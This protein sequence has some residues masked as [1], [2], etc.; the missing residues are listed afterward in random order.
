MPRDLLI[1]ARKFQ[2][3]L[4]YM[5]R[6]GL[7]GEAI[8]NPL[9]MTPQELARTA[10]EQQLLGSDYSRMYKNAA[11]QMQT[12]RWPIPWAAGI[13]SEA[14]EFMCQ[15]IITCKTLGEALERAQRYDKLLYPMIGYRMWIERDEAA[16]ELHYK[17]TVQEQDNVL[18]PEDWDRKAHV[19]TVARASGL[20]VWYSLCGWLIGRSIDL[21]RVEIGGPEVS[22]AYR[23]GLDQV[24][25]CPLQFDSDRNCFV[26]PASYLDYRLVHTPE[27]L[28]EFLDNTVYSLINTSSKPSSTSA[29]IRSLIKLDFSTGIPSFE[30]MAENLHM[31]ESSLRRRL[32]KENTSYQKIKDQIRCELAVEHLHKEQT[33]ISDLAEL[34][35]FTEPSSFVRSFRSWMGVTPK[36]YRDNL[37]TSTEG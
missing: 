17:V 20:M 27:S 32:L 13:G 8:L 7:D 15:C 18:T 5:E 6:I 14:F 37:K 19:Q 11:L 28:H 3:L 21:N 4:D 22:D 33:R 16:F 10:P 25:H 29:A 23:A 9:G 34:L 31:S 30:Q 12:L 1:P 26:A 24:L 36:A 35:G 2:R